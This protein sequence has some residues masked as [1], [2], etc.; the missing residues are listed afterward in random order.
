MVLLSQ[1]NFLLFLVHRERI[2][3]STGSA[4]FAAPEVYF[5][6]KGIPFNG[7]LA[8]IWALGG[9]LHSM[10]AASLPYRIQVWDGWVAMGTS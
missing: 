10:L 7:P 9:V 8:E 1:P 6:H 5:A 3:R 2:C 4:V